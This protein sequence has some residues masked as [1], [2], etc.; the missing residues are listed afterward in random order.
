MCTPACRESSDTHLEASPVLVPVPGLDSHVI[1][2]GKDDARARVNCEA[3]NI[4]RMGLERGDL[5]VRV[6]V[7]DPKLEIIRAGDKPVLT[8]DEAAAADGN[9]RYLE[10]FNESARLVVIDVHS[11]I[12]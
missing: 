4:I 5:L 2:T 1:A 8:R 7:E 6:V 10:R 3:S 12:I 9:L 11:A